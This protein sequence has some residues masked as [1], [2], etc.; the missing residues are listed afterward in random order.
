M[1]VPP[2]TRLMVTG[3]YPNSTEKMLPSSPFAAEND[4]CPCR[5]GVLLRV[6]LG[7]KGKGCAEQC[8]IED[9]RPAG[10]KVS[11]GNLRQLE[12]KGVDAA[13][14]SGG[15]HLQ[16]GELFYIDAAGDPAR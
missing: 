12:H 8:H 10:C 5:G 16:E 7:K 1:M 9:R 3:S 4:S 6:G 14:A 15:E 2:T 11:L 13:Q